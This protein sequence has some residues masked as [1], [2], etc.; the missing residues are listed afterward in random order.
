MKLDRAGREERHKC[1]EVT[2]AFCALHGPLSFHSKGVEGPELC[3][4]ACYPFLT[5]ARCTHT[6]L[7]LPPLG[8]PGVKFRTVTIDYKTK[9]PTKKNQRKGAQVNR[10][11]HQGDF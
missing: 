5:P 2:F 1:L 10:K 3:A 9:N 11:G 8:W 7:S 6:P 4:E